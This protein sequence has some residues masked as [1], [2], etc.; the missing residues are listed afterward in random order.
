VEDFTAPSR[1]RSE[2]RRLSPDTAYYVRPNATDNPKIA[3][4]VEFS[5]TTTDI[6][7]TVPC[8]L[9]DNQ[10][11]LIGFNTNYTY[12]SVLYNSNGITV[13]NYG[14]MAGGY[15]SNL[16]VEFDMMLKT[17]ICKTATV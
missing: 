10:L 6:P 4:R 13:V 14:L 5:F 12:T 16:R 1:Y 11:Q 8:T 2:I 3:S 15:G 7:P 17:P 9:K